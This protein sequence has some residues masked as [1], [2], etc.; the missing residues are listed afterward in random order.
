MVLVCPSHS[1]LNVNWL[2]FP[3]VN[4]FHLLVSFVSFD[5]YCNICRIFCAV[6]W[7]SVLAMFESDGRMLKYNT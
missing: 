3:L 5:Y 1:S 6:G 4:G 2:P 7:K